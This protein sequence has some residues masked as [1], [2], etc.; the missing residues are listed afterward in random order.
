VNR[1]HF[2]A[3]MI[4]QLYNNTAVVQ[5]MDQETHQLYERLIKLGFPSMD[6][7]EVIFI[8]KFRSK[9][10]RLL[11]YPGVSLD[12]KKKSV[13]K[14]IN[15]FMGTEPDPPVCPIN[16]D[17]LSEK[18]QWVAREMMSLGIS[19]DKI[20][21]I[22]ESSVL[23][24]HAVMILQYNVNSRIEKL[25]AMQSFIEDH[26]NIIAM[27]KNVSEAGNKP[28]KKRKP[29]K[30]YITIKR[31][32]LLA[33]IVENPGINIDNLTIYADFGEK[34]AVEALRD[35]AKNGL[36]RIEISPTNKKSYTATAEGVSWLFSWAG[37]NVLCYIQRNSC[38]PHKTFVHRDKIRTIAVLI[39]SAQMVSKELG[40][41][42]WYHHCIRLVF[43]R[44]SISYLVA[45]VLKIRDNKDIMNP[46]AYLYKI[47]FDRV[48]KEER[49]AGFKKK[50]LKDFPEDV[51]GMYEKVAGELEPKT[52]KY[53]AYSLRKA[54][55]T[56]EKQGLEMNAGA[57][58][59]IL[60][61]I[62]KRER[63]V[64]MVS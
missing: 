5:E 12:R 14:A 2:G 60:G 36:V 13:G 20:T 4:S 8:K 38:I 10:V 39:E 31:M 33:V 27:A 58:N 42:K 37:T 47:L 45:M 17:G 29:P 19:R 51:R 49:I 48:T 61:W 21:M 18:A 56:K 62:E 35:F 1:G 63:G 15:D 22:V 54:A 23:C 40:K 6:L 34:R 50:V 57:V 28:K 64:K 16:L 25:H 9:V 11:G 55:A 44:H 59:G 7:M 30:P 52:F 46:G 24:H 41:M 3:K 43:Q 26:D 53:L 32:R